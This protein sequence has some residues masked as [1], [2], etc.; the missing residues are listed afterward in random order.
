MSLPK[1]EPEKWNYNFFLTKSHNCYMYALNKINNR[2]VKTC[3]EYHIGKKTLKN[4]EKSYKKKWE[5]LW[6]RP[7]KAAGYVFTKPF[8]C[9]DMV[10]G[11]LLDSPLIK[12]TK[13][14]NSN[15]KCPKNYYRIALFQNQNG[16]EFHFYR[17]DRNGLWSHKNG[18]RKATN[19]DCAKQ[20]IKDPLKCKRGI[21]KVF[22]GF[23][24]V[25]CDPKKKRMSNI[26][27]KK[28]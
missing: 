16:R 3:K 28:H 7:G 24:A 13:E 8:N 5:F 4:K 10:N 23:F 14:R 18:W 21:Y 19:L 20:L 27:R 15:F 9:Q 2:L 11:I 26:T 1:W 12:Y 25:P 6:A 17:Q 22:C